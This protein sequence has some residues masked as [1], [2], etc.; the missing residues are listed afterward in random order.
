MKEK[1]CT[2]W[3]ARLIAFL[4]CLAHA[5]LTLAVTPACTMDKMQLIVPDARDAEDVC[6]G[7]ARAVTFFAEHGLAMKEPVLLEV[8]DRLP[9]NSSA[10]AAGIFLAEKREVFMLSYSAFRKFG[11]WFNTPISRDLYQSLAAHEIAHAITSAHF[12][13]DKPSVHAREYFAYVALFATMPASLRERILKTLP[14][15]TYDDESRLSLMVYLMDP[16]FFGAQSYRHYLNMNQDQRKAF[17]LAV[18]DGKAL[19]E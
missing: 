6:L 12:Q 5:G 7:A 9:A 13:R 18:L 10:T 4:A 17:F 16:M 14:G 19:A 3:Q 11:N 15:Q 2:R 8:R 1:K